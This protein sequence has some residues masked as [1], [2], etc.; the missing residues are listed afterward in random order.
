MLRAF[1]ASLCIILYLY[2]L[3]CFGAYVVI[4]LG[5]GP[6]WLVRGVL[7]DSWTL[8]QQDCA[9]LGLCMFNVELRAAPFLSVIEFLSV[10]GSKTFL[11]WRVARL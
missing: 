5:C 10:T 11:C 4:A 2:L 6:L 3:A 7:L 1:P 9:N 8:E